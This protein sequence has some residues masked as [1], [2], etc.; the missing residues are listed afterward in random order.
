MNTTI[1]SKKVF[2]KKSQQ[3]LFNYLKDLSHFRE[4]LPDDK[5]ENVDCSY[6]HCHFKVKGMAGV[7][8]KKEKEEEPERIILASDTRSQI[9]YQLHIVIHAVDPNQSEAQ[10]IFIGDLNPMLKLMIETP[11]RNFFNYLADNLE[12]KFSTT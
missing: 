8:L 12:K 11:L 10:L 1:E 5:V 2:L 7:Y 4:L 6:Q 3:E 9:L